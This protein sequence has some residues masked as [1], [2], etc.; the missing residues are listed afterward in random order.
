MAYLGFKLSAYAPPK[1]YAHNC[2]LRK[3]RYQYRRVSI[4]NKM[5]TLTQLLCSPAKSGANQFE[6][7]EK[8]QTAA[9]KFGDF[10]NQSPQ[11]P[12]LVLVSAPRIALRVRGAQE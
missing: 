6:A 12:P 1:Q 5:E 7:E 9:K 3:R 11:Q 2:S 10:P 4:L 8:S